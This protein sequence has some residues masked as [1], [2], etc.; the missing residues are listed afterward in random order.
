M[1]RLDL[2]PPVAPA[3]Q[4]NFDLAL[5]VNI[6][7]PGNLSLDDIPPVPVFDRR[8]V[9]VSTSK[10]RR[11]VSMPPPSSSTEHLACANSKRTQD[12]FCLTMKALPE[13][14]IQAPVKV[15]D[16]VPRN[17]QSGPLN[18]LAGFSKLSLIEEHQ[19]NCNELAD[20]SMHAPYQ[21]ILQPP[22]LIP[23]EYTSLRPELPPIQLRET[24]QK[25]EILPPAPPAHGVFLNANTAFKFPSDGLLDSNSVVLPSGCRDQT[26]RAV[27]STLYCG[28][29]QYKPTNQSFRELEDYINSYFQRSSDSVASVDSPTIHSCALPDAVSLS[30][31]YS[32]HNSLPSSEDS[33]FAEST[34]HTHGRQRSDRTAESVPHLPVE[35]ESP[36]ASTKQALL[37]DTDKNTPINSGSA[38]LPKQRKRASHSSSEYSTHSSRSNADFCLDLGADYDKSRFMI[39]KEQRVFSEA[40]KQYKAHLKAQKKA[41]AMETRNVSEPVDVFQN[42]TLPLPPVHTS[43]EDFFKRHSFFGHSRSATGPLYKVKRFSLR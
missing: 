9:K 21:T 1:A 11:V 2:Q 42:K 31:E 10:E 23:E 34:Q 30:S 39:P 3:A 8:R 19:E 43:E 14:P 7:T 15:A 29:L 18:L 37:Y 32:E 33:L 22:E 27:D 36:S 20:S 28:P 41:M 38:V 17:H 26:R 6:F 13:P 5:A 25:K 35:V 24:F 16:L 40:H 4:D 12:D